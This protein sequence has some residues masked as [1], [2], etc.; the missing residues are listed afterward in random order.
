MKIEL[1]IMRI[2]R[3]YFLFGIVLLSM[4]SIFVSSGCSKFLYA[5]DMANY[6]DYGVIV[7][8]PETTLGTN[9][10]RTGI[11]GVRDDIIDK[12]RFPDHPHSLPDQVVVEWQ[13]AKLSD[14]RRVDK[15]NSAVPKTDDTKIYIRKLGC[16]WTPMKDKVFRKVFDLK[17]A[18][19]SELAK[20]AGERIRFGSKRVMT[21]MFIFRDEEVELRLGGFA[22]NSLS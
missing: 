22:S 3:R 18:Q 17:E 21:I 15:Y 11:P 4:L 19:K 5:T 6:G 8:S 2:Y 9:R 12:G 10:I 16:T 1:N 20:R 13:L 14:C 7:L